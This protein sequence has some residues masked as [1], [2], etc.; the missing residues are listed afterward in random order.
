MDFLEREPH[1]VELDMD[2]LGLDMNVLAL[3]PN[4]VKL[5]VDVLG[6]AAAKCLTW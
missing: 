3:S 2:V 5:D 4:T 1:A 6:L